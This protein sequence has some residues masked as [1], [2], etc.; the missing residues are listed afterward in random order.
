MIKSLLQIQGAD[1]NPKPSGVCNS[2]EILW[3]LFVKFR[4]QLKNA[5][6]QNYTSS[7]CGI[8]LKKKGRPA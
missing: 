8:S 5:P 6:G 1:L 4:A 7:L 3:L 2:R